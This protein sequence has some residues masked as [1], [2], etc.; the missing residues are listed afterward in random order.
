MSPI[1]VEIQVSDTALIQDALAQIPPHERL[2]IILHAYQG[3]SMREIAETI[4]CTKTAV[5]MRL[6][7]ARRR[8]RAAYQ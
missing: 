4:G 1:S 2:P 5:K 7:R 8:F 6:F 3:H